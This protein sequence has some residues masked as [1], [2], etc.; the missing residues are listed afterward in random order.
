M[1]RR[2]PNPR[3][4][5]I[6]RNYTVEEAARV[7]GVHRNTVRNW[8]RQGLEPIDERKPILFLGA[9]LRAFLEG[10]R[11]KAK[12]SCP[13][14]TIYCV[15]CREPREPALRM[16]EYVS[17]SPALGNLVGI[18]PTCGNLMNRTVSLATVDAVLGDLEVQFRDGD[19]RI[20]DRSASSVTCD[21]EE[22]LRR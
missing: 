6:N 11:A 19:E 16:V 3:L 17:L 9:T 1:R 4:I 8:K 7:L 20:N 2:R 5:K 14:G 15:C 21:L 13:P 18:C 22:G 10:R 12:R